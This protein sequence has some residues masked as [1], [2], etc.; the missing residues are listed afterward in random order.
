MNRPAARRMFLFSV[1]FMVLL[2]DRATKRLVQQR[3]AMHDSIPVIPDFFSLTHVQ[4][5]GA[6]FSLFAEPA[7]QL[8]VALLI[9][10]SIFALIAVSILLWKNT[11]PRNATGISLA[12][13][14]GGAVGNLWDRLSYGEVVDFLLFYVGPHQWPVFNLADSAIVGGAFLLI[15]T[16]LWEREEKNVEA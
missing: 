11:P 16:T 3:I 8:K 13:I 4:N 1:A 10:F 14:L 2:L 15:L 12:L 6:A 7:S 9:A 5:R